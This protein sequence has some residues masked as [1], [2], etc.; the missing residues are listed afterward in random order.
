M[1]LTILYN[2]LFSPLFCY[3]RVYLGMSV[4]RVTCS[5]YKK[6]NLILPMLK[7]HKQAAEMVIWSFLGCYAK[8]QGLYTGEKSSSHCCKWKRTL[9]RQWFVHTHMKQSPTGNVF[10]L[11]C[12]QYSDRKPQGSHWLHYQWLLVLSMWSSKGHLKL[13]WLKE[14]PEVLS[15]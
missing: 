5:L 3:E 14:T 4:L 13:S 2:S 9:L 12:S 8:S 1:V 10:L 15:S 11:I 7:E 6:I